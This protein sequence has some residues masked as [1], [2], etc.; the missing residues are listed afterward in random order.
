MDLT[1]VGFRKANW[2]VLDSSYSL[3]TTDEGDIDGMPFYYLADGSSDW[4]KCSTAATAV[5]ATPGFR[6]IRFKGYFAFPVADF[7]FAIM[8]TGTGLTQE[9]LPT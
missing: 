4:V 8:P 6:R 2:G 9:L 5:S 7:G 3:F 1:E